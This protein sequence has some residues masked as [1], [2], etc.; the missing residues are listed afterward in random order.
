CHEPGRAR[1]GSCARRGAA[2]G[3]SPGRGAVRLGGLVGR[4]ARL[5]AAGT[6]APA[7][8]CGGPMRLGPLLLAVALA[9]VALGTHP[10]CAPR[11][12]AVMRMPHGLDPEMARPLARDDEAAFRRYCRN[13]GAVDI[14][15]AITWLLA[16][17]DSRSADRY[18]RSWGRAAPYLE[19]LGWAMDTEF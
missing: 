12:G 13:A 8:A 9:A 6:Y 7:H 3:A 11:R 2:R 1:P 17:L 14:R 10:S 18:A 15:G 16:G 19:R 4:G 5:P